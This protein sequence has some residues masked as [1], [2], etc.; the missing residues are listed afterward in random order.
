MS[1]T[2][3]LE[4]ANQVF[5]KSGTALEIYARPFFEGFKLI[6]V[7]QIISI[8]MHFTFHIRKRLSFFVLPDVHSN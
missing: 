4:L 5:H 3:K 7:S 6:D 2:K 1:A 8:H